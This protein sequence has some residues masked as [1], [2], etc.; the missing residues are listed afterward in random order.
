MY[1]F[2]FV[3]A[4]IFVLRYFYFSAVWLCDCDLCTLHR[5]KVTQTT[6][7]L[8]LSCY[9]HS[10]PTNSVFIYIRRVTSFI[11]HYMKF[12]D[13]TISPL[14]CIRCFLLIAAWTW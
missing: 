12:E 4:D 9:L 10:A 8:S 13:H 3:I 6:E 14:S 2:V 11:L 5:N 7:C 1:I